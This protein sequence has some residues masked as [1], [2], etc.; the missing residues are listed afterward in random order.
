MEYRALSDRSITALRM[1]ARTPLVFTD[2]DRAAL[3]H[4]RYHHPCP[5]VQQRMTVLCLLSHGETQDRAA[6]LAGVSHATAER[7][8]ARYRRD[9]IAGLRASRWVRADQCPGTPPGHTRGR[10]PGPTAPHRGRGRRPDRRPHRG[11]AEGVGRSGLSQKS[12]GLSWRRM[13]AIPLAPEE[14]ETVGPSGSWTRP[15]S[16]RARSCVV[17]GRW[18]GCLSGGRSGRRRFHVLGARNATTRSVGHGPE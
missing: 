17:S 7:Y 13:R 10:V 1:A 3:A 16:S 6:T 18:S 14:P 4:D 11:P 8:T 15:I 5:R 2:A 9:G 12:L